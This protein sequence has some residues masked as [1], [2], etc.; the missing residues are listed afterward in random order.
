MHF[1]HLHRSPPHNK[2]ILFAHDS[3]K[4]QVTKP[5]HGKIRSI[6]QNWKRTNQTGAASAKN[7]YVYKFRA[8]KDILFAH[9]SLT[10]QGTKRV[11]GKIKIRSARPK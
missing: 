9:D 8:N 11:R 6:C 7:S 3:L 5:V 4:A 2:Y 10:A 1:V